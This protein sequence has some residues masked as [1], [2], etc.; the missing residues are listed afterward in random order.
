MDLEALLFMINWQKS[1]LILARF[2]ELKWN[3]RSIIA[4]VTNRLYKLSPSDFRYLLEDCK[5]C[6][7][8][9]V[10]HGVQLP[11]IGLPGVFSKMNS[12]LQDTIQGKNLRDINSKLPSGI[13]KVKEGYIRSAPI[14]PTN[15]CFISGRFDILS[16]LEDGSFALIDFKISD[17]KEEKVKKFKHQLH[18]YK[19]ALENP[20]YGEKKKV[21]KMG[22]VVVSPETIE[23][24][25]GHAVFKSKPAWFEIEENMDNFLDFITEVSGFLGGALPEPTSACKWCVYREHFSADSGDEQEEIPF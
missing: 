6:Y 3:F 8:R 20:Q 19:F 9:K 13:I 21:S 12:L 2:Q 11:S 4:A 16:R 25:D 15:N 17:P 22:V 24:Q 5:H 14:P 23:F 7:Y 1:F 10:I 18:A